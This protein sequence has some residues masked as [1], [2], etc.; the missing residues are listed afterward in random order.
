MII[1]PLRSLFPKELR[2]I[3]S[4]IMSEDYVFPAKKTIFD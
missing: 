1:R 4:A 2:N 3:E